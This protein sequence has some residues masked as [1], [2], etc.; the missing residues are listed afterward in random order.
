M[1][2]GWHLYSAGERWRLPAHRA[3]IAL[4]SWGGTVVTGGLADGVR[5]AAGLLAGV[6]GFLLLVAVVPAFR[7]DATGIIDTV[8]MLRPARSGAAPV[9]PAPGQ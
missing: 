8:S 4:A 1:K 6:A 5:L 2:G 9:G 3:W 7:R